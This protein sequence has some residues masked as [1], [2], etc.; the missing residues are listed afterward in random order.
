[1]REEWIDPPMPDTA[2]LIISSQQLSKQPDGTY[3]VRIAN[4]L[5]RSYVGLPP[6]GTQL[7]GATGDDVI[8]SIASD[9]S[10]HARAKDAIGSD[11]RA[12]V[13]GGLLLFQYWLPDAVFGIPYDSLTR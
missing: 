13:S 12:K 8:L 6:A 10:V 4:P 3:T 2:P 11:E 7:E 5:T 1:M 9:G